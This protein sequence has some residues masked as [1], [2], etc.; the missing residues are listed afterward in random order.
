MATSKYKN[1]KTVCGGITF[2]SMAEAKRYEYL[3]MLERSG[4]ISGL[5]M[6]VEFV[7][8]PKLIKEDGR[9]ERAVKYKADF[10]YSN[11]TIGVIVEDVKGF[12]TKDYII[13]RK[14]MLEK[15]GI[16][17]REIRK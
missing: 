13:K 6:Q 4:H 12:I 17:I 11:G 16:T 14:L 15:H 7:L 5:T 2:D 8:I 1:K 10:V 9:C 3:S